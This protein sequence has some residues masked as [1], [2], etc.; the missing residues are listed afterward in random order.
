MNFRQ[1]M[2]STYIAV[3]MASGRKMT[4]DEIENFI[5]LC[6]YEPALLDS[7]ME[8]MQFYVET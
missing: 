6:R 5:K 7:S 8:M 4:D 1:C 2:L 3:T